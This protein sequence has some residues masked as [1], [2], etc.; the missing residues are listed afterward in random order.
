MSSLCRSAS[1]IIS[2]ILA[3]F[4]NIKSGPQSQLVPTYR[5]ICAFV[6][7]VP[8]VC[9][10]LCPCH[11]ISPL[12]SYS[13]YRGVWGPRSSAGSGFICR[14]PLKH[15]VGVPC[16]SHLPHRV[17]G[18]TLLQSDGVSMNTTWPCWLSFGAGL[19]VAQRSRRSAESEGNGK[20]QTLPSP[21]PLN[22]LGF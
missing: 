14:G 12:Q 17:A 6:F 4:P 8:T 21:S 7:L 13:M 18:F 16:G 15:I 19:Q 20:R 9:A 3:V 22:A 1:A 2:S 11:F 5:S 10:S